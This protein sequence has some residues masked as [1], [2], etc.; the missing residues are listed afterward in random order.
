MFFGETAITIDDKGR[1]A[2]PSAYRDA[3]SELCNNCLVVTYNPYERECL[4]LYPKSVWEQ[5]RDQV[6]GLKGQRQAHRDL[7]RKLVGSAAHVELDSSGRLLLPATARSTVGLQ[8]HAVLLG[9]GSK[10]ELWT[11]AAQRARLEQPIGDDDISDEM[12]QLTF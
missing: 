4:W 2:I 12:A 8:K 9:M 11:E 1:M 6:M 5:V 7:Q 3:V 10:F